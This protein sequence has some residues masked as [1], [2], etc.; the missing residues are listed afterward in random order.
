MTTRVGPRY[1]VEFDVENPANELYPGQA[2]QAFFVTSS[3]ENVLTVPVGALTLED[4]TGDTRRATVQAVRDNG[5]TET[6]EV[7]VRT[8]DRVNAE[9]VSGL[10]AG[11]R[12]VA[13]TVL[14]PPVVTDERDEFGRRGSRLDDPLLQP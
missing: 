1:L 6:R 5:R 12:V 8:M 9:V 14:P 2:T 3:A 11:D 4:A 13:G 10:A 7:V